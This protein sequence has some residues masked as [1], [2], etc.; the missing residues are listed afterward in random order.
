VRPGEVIDDRFEIVAVHAQG[1]M[2]RVLRARDRTS[3]APVAVKVLLH[4]TVESATRF[5]REATALRDVEH[6]HVVRYLGHGRAPEGPWLAMEWIEG[7]DLEVRLGRGTLSAAEAMEVARGIGA[8]LAALHARGI[9]HRDLKPANVLLA[10]G[11]TK[12]CK[13][14]DLGLARSQ[15]DVA[16]TLA[17]AVL[18]TPRY[19][20]P[21]QARGEQSVGPRADVFALGAVLYECLA[22]R[23]AFAGTGVLEV[24]AN[25]LLDS[26]PSLS[27]LRADVPRELAGLVS[28]ALDKDPARRPADGSQVL[29]LLADEDGGRSEVG[30]SSAA[31]GVDEQRTQSLVIVGAA[32][33]TAAT[34]AVEHGGAILAA[35]AAVADRYG[36][37]CE[38][39]VE[40][41]ALLVVA[42]TGTASDDAAR[43]ARLA[44]EIGDR[45]PGHPVALATA[46]GQRSARLPTGEMARRAGN[47][48]SQMRSSTTPGVVVDEITAALVRGRFR[49][50]ES[51][52]RRVLV[53]AEDDLAREAHVLGRAVPCVGRD[54]EI[55]TRLGLLDDTLDERT[56]RVALVTAVPGAG[57]SRLAREILR[58]MGDRDDVL[59]L[60]ARGDSMT[61]GSALSMLAAT[62]RHASCP[63]GEDGGD[64][65]S[66]VRARLATVLPRDGLDLELLVELATGQSADPRVTAFRSDPVR[67]GDATRLAWESWMRSESERR[68][69]ALVLD[70]LHWGDRASVAAIDRAL[71]VSA[72]VCLFVLALA[73]PN[74]RELFPGLFEGRGAHEIQLSVLS[75]RACRDLAKKLLG[76]DASADALR[77]VVERGDGNPFHLEELARMAASGNTDQAPGSVLAMIESRLDALPAELRRVLRAASVFGE[78]FDARGP[79]ALLSDLDGTAV[80]DAVAAL[81]ERELFTDA[82]REGELR[83]HHP[84]IREVAYETLTITDRRLAHGA[85]ARWLVEARAGT[86]L[87]IAEHHARAGDDAGA[88]PHFADA[89]EAALAG[90]DYPAVL[91]HAE[92]ALAGAGPELV[93][94]VAL[95]EACALRCLSRPQL[96]GDRAMVALETS[97]MGGAFGARPSGG[98]CRPRGRYASP[99]RG[100]LWER[101]LAEP[102]S[103]GSA[104]E[105]KIIALARAVIPL[106]LQGVPTAAG[107]TLMA[108]RELASVGEIGAIARAQI[109]EAEAEILSGGDDL[110][111]AVRTYEM[112]IAAWERAGLARER[113]ACQATLA[114]FL[115]VLGSGAGGEALARSALGTA[116]ALGVERA[117]LWARLTLAGVLAGQG[118]IDEAL[119]YVRGV[120]A[121]YLEQGVAWFA[122]SAFR[123]EALLET[124]AGRPAVA[125]ALLDPLLPSAHDTGEM[126]PLQRVAIPLAYARALVGRVERANEIVAKADL[127]NRPYAGFVHLT[128]TPV[129]IAALSALGRADDAAVLAREALR[130]RAT[131][132]DTLPPER[133]T[134]AQA[135][136]SNAWL[137]RIADGIAEPLPVDCLSI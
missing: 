71:R 43:A 125:E 73:R 101:A 46:R 38:P 133:R 36:A 39:L 44:L 90:D 96:A 40:G 20:A 115:G 22:G 86:P 16:L 72:S 62:V 55:A 64:L 78:H 4:T 83:F 53:A 32:D 122:V 126:S 45:V 89:A 118:R 61:A 74:V 48:A 97:A 135:R 33:V 80:S 95:L 12:R 54:R 98:G 27:D 79:A 3:G 111:L 136:P 121:R 21:E 112:A 129:L 100:P 77:W 88:A 105:E 107:A 9:V 29:T 26:P 5:V 106:I 56:S 116:E 130:Q 10:G 63:G 123:L 30:P 81:R 15:G 84:L 132:Y 87:A 6:P 23:H 28:R 14:V 104:R 102:F 8:A 76:D 59:V 124:S 41:S 2:G 17:G 117:R 52:E 137:A 92:R 91:A 57:K 94:R 128:D 68:C 51:G 49:I 108:A 31:L 75:T 113:A 114:G 103:S 60:V 99:A 69:I 120:G 67:L 25:V 13:L 66:R 131:L 24:L 34:I 65:A 127:L 19:M 47:L 35:L 42:G 109:G 50:D 1:G 93:P 110:G 58:R 134:L 7:E 119:G 70:D 11:D 82:G 37:R 18:G 85:A